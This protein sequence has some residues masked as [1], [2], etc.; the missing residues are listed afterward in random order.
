MVNPELLI[1]QCSL[2]RDLPMV[3]ALTQALRP[4]RPDQQQRARDIRPFH[5]E[6]RVTEVGFA[7]VS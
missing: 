1:N 6:L 7:H 3:R 2:L 5:S 4:L